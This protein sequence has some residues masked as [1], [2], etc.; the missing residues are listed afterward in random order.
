MYTKIYQ[1]SKNLINDICRD[2]GGFIPISV[3][4]QY[5]KN[6]SN[7]YYTNVIMTFDT[8]TSTVFKYPNGIW[9]RY[10]YVFD[11]KNNWIEQVKYI[12]GVKLY[13]WKRKIVYW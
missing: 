6:K 2:F 5:H 9:D 7:E 1:Y 8:E 13:V 3:A 12:N 4:T 10:H 11:E